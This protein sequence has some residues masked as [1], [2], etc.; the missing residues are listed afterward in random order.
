M[1]LDPILLWTI[2]PRALHIGA[3]R[4]M[5]PSEVQG[6]PAFGNGLDAHSPRSACTA[7]NFLPT[8]CTYTI[9]MNHSKEQPD[10]S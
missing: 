10:Y 7:E 3:I 2:F 8:L 5:G 9:W 4:L 6:G 1:G